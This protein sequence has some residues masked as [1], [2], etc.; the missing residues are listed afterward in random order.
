MGGPRPRFVTGCVATT[1]PNTASSILRSYVNS[2]CSVSSPGRAAHMDV[3]PSSKASRVWTTIARRTT[4][5]AEEVGSESDG[6]SRRCPLVN[7]M[8]PAR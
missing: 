4:K 8:Y 3:Q 6:G 7:L 5:A 2:T 1:S